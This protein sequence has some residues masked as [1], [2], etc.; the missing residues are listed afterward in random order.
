VGLVLAIVI[1]SQVQR[2]WRKSR[3]VAEKEEVTRERNVSRLGYEQI[4]P[5]RPMKIRVS[6][7]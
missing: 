3:I 2:C 4:E 7:K 6:L 5:R 1:A